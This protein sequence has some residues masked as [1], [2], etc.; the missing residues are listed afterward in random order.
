MSVLAAWE[1][2]CSSVQDKPGATQGLDTACDANNSDGPCGDEFVRRLKACAKS[3]A[4]LRSLELL[5]VKE[6]LLRGPMEELQSDKIAEL[7][8]AMSKIK[9][10]ADLVVANKFKVVS[11]LQRA[12]DPCCLL[13]EREGQDDLRFLLEEV[14]Q[15]L[16]PS[17]DLVGGDLTVQERER[18]R[19]QEGQD[20]QGLG[21]GSTNKLQR[22]SDKSTVELSR[23]EAKLAELERERVT[24]E[25]ALADVGKALTATSSVVQS[26]AKLPLP[27]GSENNGDTQPVVLAD[28]VGATLLQ[29]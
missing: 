13:V 19:Q 14:S 20:D 21:L 3:K 1:Q 28:L 10:V 27:P 22:D 15:P 8:A 18:E 12:S 23:L 17:S 24:L 26:V 2:H 7:Q 16:S 5:K 9:R 6:N 11:L 29:P 4:Q 25:V